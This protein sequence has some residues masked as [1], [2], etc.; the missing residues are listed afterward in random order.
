MWTAPISERT[1][2][3]LAWQKCHVRGFLF[4][5][6]LAALC[7]FLYPAIISLVAS[8]CLNLQVQQRRDRDAYLRT[9]MCP[10]P[11]QT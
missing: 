11:E 4:C 6:A 5:A 10:A 1:N 9:A 3:P 7:A 2:K 8:R